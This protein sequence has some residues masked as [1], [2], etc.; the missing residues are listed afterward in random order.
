MWLILVAVLFV[1]V[2]DGFERLKRRR[3]QADEDS[4]QLFAR[5]EE[6]NRSADGA[7]R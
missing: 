7:E 5:R 6:R 4:R 3:P 1:R 2:G